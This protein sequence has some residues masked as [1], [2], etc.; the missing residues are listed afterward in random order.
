M[1]ID[2]IS[3]IEG[4]HEIEGE[5][6]DLPEDWK[7]A[8]IG[9]ITENFDSERNPVSKSKRKNIQGN[10][11][12]YG[13]S[14]IIDHL[15]DYILDGEYLLISED[16]AN[17]ESRTKSIAF[18]VDGEFWPNN[19][20]HVVKT[21]YGIP[22]DY[23][24]LYVESRSI[25][26]YLTGTAQLKLTQKNLNKIPV[27]IAP[28]KEQKRIIDKIEEL[29][30]KLDSG[31]RAL[32]TAENR[33]NLYHSSVIKSAITGELA[34]RLLTENQ[35]SA[36]GADLVERAE[37]KEEKN[38]YKKRGKLSDI[39]EDHVF[40]VPPSWGW[41]RVGD[42]CKEIRYGSSEK[43]DY[44]FEGDPILR[45]G[46]IE[47]G[48]LD[49]EDLKYLP[50]DWE[51]EELMLKNGDVLFN[52]TNSAE[53]VGKTALYKE[54]HPR[55]TFASYL[56]RARVYPDIYNP[57]FL[58][59][60]TNSVFGRQYINEVISQ[61]VGQANVNATKFASMPIPV[62]S[63]EEQDEIV[64]RIDHRLSIVDQV[65]K[66]VGSNIKRSSRLRRSILKHAFEGD[67][68]PHDPNV[69]PSTR[70]GGNKNIGQGT[71]TTLSEVTSDVE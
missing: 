5:L 29:F 17:L 3:E 32:K 27:P 58:V 52:R 37:E 19:H 18:I 60:F 4:E 62:P 44:Q 39:S 67:L 16:G 66:A 11:P 2:E 40:D 61:Q 23:L 12:Y 13:A 64:R 15:N 7:W 63:I 59:Y 28:Q 35:P 65:A 21:R 42:V 69:E 8:T 20:V 1:K 43:A 71:Q 45:M 55:S 48:K 49:F 36:S 50:A 33:L 6:G 47:N 46:N 68:V 9:E 30:S 26:E 54:N 38:K 31:T 53:L 14:G 56:V 41:A 34:E 22:L 57:A 70:D 24:R 10:Y 51:R 25:R